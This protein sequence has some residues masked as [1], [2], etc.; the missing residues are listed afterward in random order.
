M[1]QVTVNEAVGDF[2]HIIKLTADELKAI[3]TGNSK[4]IFTMPAGSAV[5]LVG[6]M[7]TI[8]IVGSSS[9]VVDVGIS[10]AATAF[11]NNWDVDAAT[12]NLPVFN[13]G[14]DFVQTAGNTT[15]RGGA[16]P[17][18]AV[19]TATPILLRVTDASLASITA[20]EIEVG[21]RL[22]NMGRF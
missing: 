4:T 2:T 14:T 18:R 19:A 9:L 8:D 22:I 20:G 17:V 12:V 7:N 6:V 13:T 21:I 3:G 16:L 15:I 1:P 5:D 10:G 11:I